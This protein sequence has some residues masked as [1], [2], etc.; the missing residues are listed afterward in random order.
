MLFIYGTVYNS[1]NRVLSSLDSIMKINIEKRIFI[2][3]NYSTDGTYELLCDNADKYNLMVRQ[4]K[5]TR[6]WGRHLAIEM[7]EQYAKENDMFFFIDLDTVYNNNFVSLIEFGYNNMDKNSVFL[8]NHLCYYEANH[9]VQWKDLTAAEDVEREA[10]FI[11]LGYKLT[12][13]D[14][15]ITYEENEKV[16]FDREKRYAH[17][18][19]YYRR[20]I[21]SYQDYIRG[22]GCNNIRNMVFYMRNANVRKRFYLAYILIY[23]YVKMFKEIYNYYDNSE[24]TNIELIREKSVFIPVSI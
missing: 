22:A 5:C 2:I 19:E 10:R 7:A 1:R 21:R 13:P 8:D 3:D 6:G 18:R 14:H 20:K 4:E 12:Y 16:S 11:S 23:L 9:N 15:E 17:G 24:K